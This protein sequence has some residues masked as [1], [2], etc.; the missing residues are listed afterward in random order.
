MRKCRSSHSSYVVPSPIAA[1]DFS[2]FRMTSLLSCPNLRCSSCSLFRPSVISV[3][4]TPLDPLRNFLTSNLTSFCYLGSV[5]SELSRPLHLPLASFR[6]F[7]LSRRRAS[8]QDLSSLS[9]ALPSS[10]AGLA[11]LSRTSA[12][13]CMQVP[14]FTIR[15]S[16]A[17]LGAAI[18][19]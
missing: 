13:W 6:I 18:L 10:L 4:C 1:P 16:P 2:I 19:G 17:R 5:S 3:L 14:L 8:V 12:I 15:F 7:A 11:V 9:I